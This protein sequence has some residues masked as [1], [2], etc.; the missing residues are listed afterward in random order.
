MVVFHVF[1]D[2]DFGDLVRNR[3]FD[4]DENGGLVKTRHKREV[5]PLLTGAD[6]SGVKQFVSSLLIIKAIRRTLRLAMPGHVDLADS[7]L[8]ALRR[9]TADEYAVY[10]RSGAQRFSHFADHYD[11][12]IALDAD[13]ESSKLK[14]A[15]MRAVLQEASNVAISRGIGFLVLIQPSRVDLTDRDEIN[16]KY[17]EKYPKYRNSRLTDLVEQICRD[18]GIR[19]VNLFAPFQRNRPD[20][21]YFLGD[22]NHWN[23]QGE[24]LAARETATYIVA[25]GMLAGNRR[26]DGP[27]DDG[28]GA[29]HE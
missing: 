10:K 13:E 22:D 4:L 16:Y 7:K 18:S 1:A 9:L 11:I 2:N 15:L 28:S 26:P 8:D 3:L 27:G 19:Y 21:L 25:H 12:D 23:D 14:V 24:D 17:L 5:D 29:L 6:G 20:D